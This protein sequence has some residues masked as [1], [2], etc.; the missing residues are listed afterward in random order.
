MLMTLLDIDWSETSRVVI[1]GIGMVFIILVLLIFVIKIFGMLF[2]PK[3]LVRKN[4]QKSTTSEPELKEEEYV[5]SHLTAEC[6]AAI[7]MALHLYYEDVHDLENTIVTIKRVEKRYS[8]WNS[9][10]YGLTNLVR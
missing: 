10:I 3:V 2:A 4:T 1:L 5:E 6:S 7:G 8:P 9:K